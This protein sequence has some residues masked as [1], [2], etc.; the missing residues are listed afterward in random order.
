MIH[1]LYLC[2]EVLDIA[3]PVGGYNP[4]AAWSTGYVVGEAAVGRS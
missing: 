4:Q 2:G 1:G 3:G